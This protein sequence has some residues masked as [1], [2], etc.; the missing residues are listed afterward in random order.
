MEFIRKLGLHVWKPRELRN[1]DEAA[2]SNKTVS[3]HR[4][5]GWCLDEPD[6]GSGPC[7]WGTCAF[8]RDGKMVTE[9][10]NLILCYYF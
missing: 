3:D 2:F 10:Q 1:V 7:I 4:D 9:N 6:V 8:S 5:S